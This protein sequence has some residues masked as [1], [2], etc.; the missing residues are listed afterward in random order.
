MSAI[1]PSD[2]RLGEPGVTAVAELKS[3]LLLRER[4][5]MAQDVGLRE[6]LACE[7]AATANTFVAGTE[8]ACAAEADD[9]VIALLH[10]ERDELRAVQD[11]LARIAD[12]TYGECLECGEP[13]GALRLSVLPEAALCVGCQGM[14]EHRAG[15]RASLSA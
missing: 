12:G 6:R 11:A 8:G 1:L 14:A 2:S 7:Q 10:H 3:R 4:E 15:H 13:I 9:E 5:L